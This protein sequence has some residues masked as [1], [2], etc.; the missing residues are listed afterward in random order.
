MDKNDLEGA[1][2]YPFKCCG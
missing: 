1:P 2:R